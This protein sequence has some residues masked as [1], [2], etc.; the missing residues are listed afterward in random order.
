VPAFG[1][2]NVCRLD[3][4]VNDAF[5]M[6]RVER[7]RDLNPQYQEYFCLQWPPRDSVLEGH[8]AQKLH[9]DEC[10]PVLIVN[11][12]DRANVGMIQRGRS[13]GFA[14][15]AAES[16]WVFGYVVG[17]EFKGNEAIQL[18]VLCLV[19]HTHTATTEPLDDAVMRDILA[20]H[21]AQ[22]L[23]LGVGQVNEDRSFGRLKG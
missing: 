9:S 15:E 10:L 13:F 2:K 8:T 16:L 11:F 12:V 18:N 1:D 14:L 4:A 20:D 22:I 23:G 21:W 17:Q 6:R 5:L 19:H 7:I 3:V